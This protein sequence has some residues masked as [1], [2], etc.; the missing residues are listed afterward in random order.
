[1]L[2]GILKWRAGNL[3][4]AKI[5]KMKLKSFSRVNQTTVLSMDPSRGYKYYF[6]IDGQLYSENL[7]VD[8][9]PV[10]WKRTPEALVSLTWK[11]ATE[12]PALYEEI[13]SSQPGDKEDVQMS[14]SNYSQFSGQIK[15]EYRDEA[16]L[17]RRWVNDEQNSTAMTLADVVNQVNSNA[18]KSLQ[19]QGR[20]SKYVVENPRII[21]PKGKG[22]VPETIVEKLKKIEDEDKVLKVSNITNTGGGIVTVATPRSG[23]LRMY[24]GLKIASNNKEA[25]LIALQLYREQLAELG[26]KIP[27]YGDILEWAEEAW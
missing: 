14:L 26:R 7:E 21:S 3:G 18:N 20:I 24:P 6:E 27:N 25:Y 12:T 22:R 8:N 5:R 17:R 23:A 11:F 16:E 2:D 4:M 1:M 9:I 19:N 10:L 13:L 15:Q